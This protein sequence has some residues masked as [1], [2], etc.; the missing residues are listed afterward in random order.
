M[1]EYFGDAIILNSEPNGDLDSRISL[2][3]RQYGKLAAKAK[4]VR[5]ITSKLAGHL[6]PGFFADVR[7]VEKSGLQ[8]VDALKRGKS[9]ISLADLYFLDTLLHEAEPDAELWRILVEGRFNWPEVLKLLGWDPKVASCSMCRAK[10]PQFFYTR[11]Q[12]FFCEN[13]VSNLPQNDII[14][15]SRINRA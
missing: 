7:L 5:K 2:F 8:V 3:T 12:D 4:S 15:L 11:N 13:C 10:S 14:S 9:D 6:Q 1:Q